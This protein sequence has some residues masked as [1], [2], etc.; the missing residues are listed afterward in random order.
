MAE[1]DGVF[2]IALLPDEMFSRSLP[3]RPAPSAAKARYAKPQS[4]SV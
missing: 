2:D 1:I 4:N 3:Q